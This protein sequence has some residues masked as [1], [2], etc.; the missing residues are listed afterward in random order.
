MYPT[1]KTQ[2]YLNPYIH[3]MQSKDKYLIVVGGPTASGKTNFA[4]QLAKHFRTEIISSD[5]RQ[6]YREMSIGT[7]KPSQNELGAIPHHLIDHLSIHDE[8]SI[9]AFEREAISLLNGMYQKQ[10]IVI[11]AGGSG[12]YIKALCEGLDDFPGVPSTVKASLQ[13]W[14]ETNGLEALQERVAKRDP[15]YFAVVDQQNPHRLL[16]AL[17]VM[18]VSGSPFSSFHKKQTQSRPFI[19]IYLWLDWP[20]EILYE[21]IN[22]RVDQMVRNGLINEAKQLFSLKHLTALQTVGYQELFTAFEGEISIEEAIDLIKRNS[23]RYAKRQL[24]WSRRDGFWKHF[25]PTE[26]DLALE[27]IDFVKVGQWQFAE[28]IATPRSKKLSLYNEKDT[29]SIQLNEFKNHLEL[30]NFQGNDLDEIATRFLMHEVSL[31]SQKP[32]TTS[33][34]PENL[35][36]PS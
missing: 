26:I 21:R 9:G 34:I 23:R 1:F 17:A 6:F 29:F 31:R 4:I 24:T 12:M 18:E 11:L 7:A 5:S 16:R 22:L 36:K 20:R 10:D 33:K 14:Y 28:E 35:Q 30:D 25:H 15:D 2:K 19:P 3:Q 8:Y 27:Y 13:E 32:I